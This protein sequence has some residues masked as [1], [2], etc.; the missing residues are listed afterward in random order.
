MD[1]HDFDSQTQLADQL[2]D[3]AGDHRGG[4]DVPRS[5]GAE[6]AGDR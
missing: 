1:H 6:I 4:R 5:G 2:G 3:F